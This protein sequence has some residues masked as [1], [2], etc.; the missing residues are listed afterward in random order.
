MYLRT[1]RLFLLFEGATFVAASLVHFG[2]LL[3]GYR[4]QQAGT[5][6]AVIAAVLMAGLVLTWS[7]SPWARRAAIGAHAFAILGVLVGL[8]TIAVGVGP[9]TALDIAYHVGILAVLIV[10]LAIAIRRPAT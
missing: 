4:H 2:K 9:R 3:E 6:E 8:F 1:I 5:A 7:P 10:G